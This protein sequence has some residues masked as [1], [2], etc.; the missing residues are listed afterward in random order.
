MIVLAPLLFMAPVA[1]VRSL[2]RSFMDNIASSV[3]WAD[4]IMKLNG[5]LQNLNLLVGLTC[6]D[7]AR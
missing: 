2:H 4:F 6:S 1:H 3:E 7:C 5:Q